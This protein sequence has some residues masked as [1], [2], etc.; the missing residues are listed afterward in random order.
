MPRVSK[1][2]DNPA[3]HGA[4]RRDIGLDPVPTPERRS[5]EYLRSFINAEIG[6]WAVPVKAARLAGGLERVGTK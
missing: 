6:K 2:L 4:A 5:A 1:A 3:M